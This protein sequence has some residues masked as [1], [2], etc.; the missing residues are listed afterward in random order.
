[1]TCC[2]LAYSAPASLPLQPLAAHLPAAGK[3]VMQRV[4]SKGPVADLTR[5]LVARLTPNL[6]PPE[7]LHA[8]MEAAGQSEEG[9]GGV[10]RAGGQGSQHSR[11]LSS[12]GCSS[13]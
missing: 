12:G 3:D 4:G 2:Q 5:A 13:P 7:V 11:C 9:E 6:L 8:A 10:M 1:M